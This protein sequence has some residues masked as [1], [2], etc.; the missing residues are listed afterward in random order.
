MDTLPTY[1]YT[2]KYFDQSML[3]SMDEKSVMVETDM[4][5]IDEAKIQLWGAILSSLASG[6]LNKVLDG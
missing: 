1:A 2:A 4:D 5:L 6:V 3:E